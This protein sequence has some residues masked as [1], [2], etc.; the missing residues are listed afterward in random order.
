MQPRWAPENYSPATNKEKKLKQPWPH[1]AAD[2]PWETISHVRATTRC[3]ARR[4]LLQGPSVGLG[5]RTPTTRGAPGP[6]LFMAV[7]YTEPI[8]PA[9]ACSLRGWEMKANGISTHP[10]PNGKA[11]S[12][13]LS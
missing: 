8:S 2:V 13:T 7:I 1:T 4:G 10:A 6:Y 11:R 12:L 3:R 9:A 5:P